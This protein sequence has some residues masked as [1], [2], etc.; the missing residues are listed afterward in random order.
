MTDER[1]WVGGLPFRWREERAGPLALRVL[2]AVDLERH[3]DRERLLTDDAFEPP[4]WALVWSGARSLLEALL[5]EGDLA[6]RSLLDAGCGLG[7]VAAFAAA[8]GARV[9]AADREP[10][11][12]EAAALIAAAN[13][14]AVEAVEAAFSEIAPRRFECV[15]AS[16]VL[17]DA[18]RL[19]EL[20]HEL[21]RLVEPGG[22]LWVADARRIDTAR[23]FDELGR[24][25]FRTDRER[26]RVVLEEGSRVRLTVRRLRAPTRPAGSPRRSGTRPRDRGGPVRPR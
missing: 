14:L 4:Y 12:L 1:L 26:C 5:E 18:G 10:A 9:T 23:F 25:G 16:E 24:I 11:A 2:E 21:S 17:Y 19:P 22:S 20:A 7:L 8:A 13:G 15:A 3:L 6:G